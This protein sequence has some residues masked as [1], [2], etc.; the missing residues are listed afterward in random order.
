VLEPAL[1]QISSRASQR[2]LNDVTFAMTRVSRFFEQI[3][4][5]IDHI[6]ELF[7][8]CVDM[9][10]TGQPKVS[11]KAQ[12]IGM[13]LHQLRTNVASSIDELRNIIQST[14][15]K[16]LIVNDDVVPVATLLYTIMH[17]AQQT[18][19]LELNVRSLTMLKRPKGYAD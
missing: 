15:A 19:A 16:I 9:L 14:Q 4:A 17:L 18:L 13:V 6:N 12:A 5:L 11:N 3:R 2:Q 1:R 8:L 7:E 10:H